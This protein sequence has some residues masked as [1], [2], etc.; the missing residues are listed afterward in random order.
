MRHETPWQPQS[1]ADGPVFLTADRSPCAFRTTSNADLRIAW[2]S[3]GRGPPPQAA[4]QRS[5]T[6]PICA[7]PE[8][9]RST[10]A[11]PAGPNL[12]PQ[13]RSAASRPIASASACGIVRWHQQRV[14]ARPRD[15]PAAWNVGRDQRA[16]AAAAWSVSG[17]PSR[18][19][20]STAMLADAQNAAM[21][22]TNPRCL[23][24]GRL[25]QALISA[26]GIE[27][28]LASGSPAINSRMSWPREVRR[29]CAAMR[30]RMPLS[31]TSRPA[32]A[33]VIGPADSG[34]A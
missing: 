29:S 9:S 23:R 18:R 20:G 24:F 26:S 28:R 10:S 5:T 14:E 22:S 11:R 3:T 7:A 1:R 27:V 33:M 30:V 4:R 16:P 17:N 31:S 13:R 12:R 21:Y 32:K 6:R 2:G 25:L 19:D 8:N 15:F 34:A